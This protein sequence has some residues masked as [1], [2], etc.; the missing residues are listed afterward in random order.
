MISPERNPRI[1]KKYQLVMIHS[2]EDEDNSLKDNWEGR[3]KAIKN[4]FQALQ[5]QQNELKR[6]GKAKN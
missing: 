2:N 6:K 5:R 4:D 1:S 3:M